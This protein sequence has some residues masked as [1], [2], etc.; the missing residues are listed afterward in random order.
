MCRW[1]R[2]SIVQ[3]RIHWHRK[4][5]AKEFC[6]KWTLWRNFDKPM[7]SQICTKFVEV[8][9]SHI[10]VVLEFFQLCFKWNYFRDNTSRV[11]LN[12]SIDLC[13]FQMYSSL[14]ISYTKLL[15]TIVRFIHWSL[16]RNWLICSLTYLFII[17][18]EIRVKLMYCFD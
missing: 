2:L 6:W 15:E 1:F 9:N 13:L 11:G 7:D 8:K 4:K 14:F 12:C 17:S 18:V 3:W 5:T 16:S 10:T